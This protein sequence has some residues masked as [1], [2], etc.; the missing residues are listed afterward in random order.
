MSLARPARVVDAELPARAMR[1]AAAVVPMAE[2][3]RAPR[4]EEPVEERVELEAAPEVE[5]RRRVER[6]EEPGPVSRAPRPVE[7][8][9]VPVQVRPEVEVEAP[10]GE[11]RRPRPVAPEEKVARRTGEQPRSEEPRRADSWS[12]VPEPTRA[13]G[14]LFLVHALEY[15]GLPQMLSEQPELRERAVAEHFL[16]WVA[17][18]LGVPLEDP[19]LR[20]L[21]VE[22]LPPLAAPCGF[23]LTER[24]RERSGAVLPARGI[25]QGDRTLEV[26]ARGRLVLS[27]R[28]SSPEPLGGIPPDLELLLRTLYLAT[29]RLLRTRARLSLRALVLRPGRIAATSTHLD[30]LFDHTQAELH[31]RRAGLDVDPGW[32]PWLGRVIRYHYLHGELPPT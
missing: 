14:L 26:D 3:A 13:G 6:A 24:L 5:E 30:V 27:L 18:R 4:P 11:A 15:L 2:R 8:P 1:V 22:E 32:V 12:E 20:A 9:E 29:A 16:A 7:E 25:I 31:I 17:A 21:R 23:T 19:V 28:H 10:R